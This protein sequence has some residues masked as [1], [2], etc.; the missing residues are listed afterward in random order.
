MA[1]VKTISTQKILAGLLVT[2]VFFAL[3]YAVFYLATLEIK[4]VIYIGDKKIEVE[5]AQT[6]V[7]R[8]QGLSN[9]KT[10][11]Q[12]NGMLFVFDGYYIPTF[13][14]RDMLFSIDI[15]WIKDDMVVGFE[16]NMPRSELDKDLIAYQ[17]K[18]FINY[19]LEV[20]A[21]FVEQNNI[22]IG[23]KVVIGN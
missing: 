12:N 15:I 7:E 14:M 9:R 1:E 8:Y 19:V 13:V 11:D 22:K 18:N 2:A 6:E 17:P 21:G 10:L 20:N 5:L 16:K 3:V 4:P 23:D